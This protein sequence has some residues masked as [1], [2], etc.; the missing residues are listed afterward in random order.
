MSAWLGEVVKQA[1]ADPAKA[2]TRYPYD[3]AKAMEIEDKELPEERDS[4]DTPSDES[5]TESE[6]DSASQQLRTR[7]LTV[8][9]E[10]KLTEPKPTN[11][12]R[13]TDEQ[14]AKW[15][16]KRKKKMKR[17]KRR[18]SKKQHSLRTRTL[19][20]EKRYYERMRQLQLMLAI[21]FSH[22][23]VVRFLQTQQTTGPI[24]MIEVVRAQFGSISGVQKH[25][26]AK[27]FEQTYPKPGQN[28]DMWLNDYLSLKL[29]VESNMAHPFE[30][31]EMARRL[32]EKLSKHPAFGEQHSFVLFVP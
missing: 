31:D 21:A 8:K 16:E 20:K 3:I 15:K 6:A 4:E 7:P 26:K 18:A 30:D 5:D 12:N 32:L 23:T 25:V 11:W 1:F 22:H 14:K 27:I 13:L 17:E 28:V 9:K 29:E 2:K 10:G 24:E 19:T